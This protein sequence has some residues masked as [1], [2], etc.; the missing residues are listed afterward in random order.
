MKKPVLI[1]LAVYFA[2]MLA[3]CSYTILLHYDT[4]QNGE[5]YKFSVIPRDPYD[6]F[7]GRYVELRTENRVPYSFDGSVF[8]ALLSKN[9]LGFAE[10][11]EF[12]KEK[13]QSGAYAKNLRLERYYMNEKMAPEAE[14]VTMN[15]DKYDSM[16]V[17]V[18]VKNGNYVI[19]GLYVD[20]VPIE[21]FIASRL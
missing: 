2:L 7:L 19:E 14:K 16:Y 18:K 6:P 13:P 15:P 9:S 17:L 11:S 1:V 12:T 21:D 20:D 8:Y 4:L 3:F 5:D 10:V